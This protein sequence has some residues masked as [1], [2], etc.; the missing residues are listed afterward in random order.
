MDRGD[1]AAAANIIGSARAATVA[2]CAT[3]PEDEEALADSEDLASLTSSLGD[4]GR[5]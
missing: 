3:R 5:D 4:R 1:Y 2:Y